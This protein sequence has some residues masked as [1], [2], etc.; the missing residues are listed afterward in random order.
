MKH[1]H[2]IF[3]SLTAKLKSLLTGSNESQIKISDA[4]YTKLVESICKQIKK[5]NWRPSCV[6]GITRGGLLPAVMI[7]H[8]FDV[9]M[10]SLDISLRDGGE[11]TSNLWLA[12]EAFGWTPKEELDEQLSFEISGLPASSARAKKDILIVDDINDQGATINW[13]IEDWRSGCLPN[14]PKWDSIWNHNVKFAVVV[15]NAASKCN[16]K[17]DFVGKEIDKSKKDTWVVFPYEE[18]WK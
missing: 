12:E 18:W 8:Y 10:Y 17:M 7:S 15:N 16:V 2:T 11:C 13:L 3:S 9:K 5:S 1:Q 4:E 6:V 14:D